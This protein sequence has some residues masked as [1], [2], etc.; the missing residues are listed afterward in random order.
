MKLSRWVLGEKTRLTRLGA[1]VL[2]ASACC[3]GL[4]YAQI[5]QTTTV[6]NPPSGGWGDAQSSSGALTPDGSIVV[7]SSGATNLVVPDLNIQFDA[8]WLDRTSGTLLRVDQSSAGI[9]AND[10]SV[11]IGVSADGRHVLLGSDATNLVPGDSNATPDIFVHDIATGLTTRVSV[12][13]SGAQANA[14]GGRCG[15]SGDGNYVVFDS[16]STNLVPGDTN[17]FADVFLHDRLSGTTS[18]IS[19]GQGGAQGNSVSAEPSISADGRWVAYATAS[20]NI[21]VPDTTGSPNADVVVVDLLTFTTRR[22]SQT[23]GGLQATGD[24]RNPRISA[25][26]RFVAFTTTA[27]NLYPGNGPGN[28]IYVWDALTGDLRPAS[29]SS[30]G[31]AGNNES[32]D[33]AIS[34]DGRFVAF[35]SFATNLIPGSSGIPK[36]IVH[37]MLLG[38]N[39]LASVSNTGASANGWSKL[40]AISGDGQHVMFTCEATNLIPGTPYTL[41][42]V[43]VSDCSPSAPVSYCTPKANSLGCLPSIGSS[44]LSSA[45]NGSGFVISGSNVRNNKPGLLIYSNSGRAALPFQGGLLCIAGQFK[46]SIP[47]HSGGSAV[48]VNDCSGVYA[49]DVNAFTVGSLGGAPASFLTVVGTLVDSQFWGRDQGFAFPDNSTLSAGLEFMVGP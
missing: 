39:R 6:S 31:V 25:D 24:S 2:L 1:N 13:S 9:Q 15:I 49:M 43:Y 48:P 27:T 23:A 29:V 26:G 18:R 34:G 12:S 35:E 47:L 42:R 17:G 30:S 37:D 4:G 40:A 22:A 36:L 32:R 46:R 19:V 28:D 21:V 3:H 45:T 33:C 20:T 10:Y 44:G 14:G 5:C 16:D 38:T 41:D 7:F 8:Y 11:A